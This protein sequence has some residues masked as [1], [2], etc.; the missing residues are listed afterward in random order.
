M[1]RSCEPSAGSQ[2][3]FAVVIASHGRP[4]DLAETLLSVEAQTLQP[5]Q[6]ILSVA[7]SSDYSETLGPRLTNQTVVSGR[8][9]LTRQRNNAVLKVDPTISF[10]TFLDDDVELASS[11]LEAIRSAFA[12]SPD[13][14]LISG[15]VLFD[16]ESG[17]HPSF[18]CS[19]TNRAR[20][21]RWSRQ[22]PTGPCNLFS[23]W[24]QHDGSRRYTEV[25][26]EI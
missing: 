9:G 20:T 3:Q 5:S 24:V 13:A 8:A 7:D 26:H 19:V 15:R 10:V 4:A 16:G 22:T 14:G 11:Y 12:R 25:R 6:V 18:N 2:P 17:A 1:S 23:V 21:R